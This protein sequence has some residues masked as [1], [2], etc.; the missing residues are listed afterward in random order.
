VGTVAFA[1]ICNTL[2]YI[3]YLVFTFWAKKAVRLSKH[4]EVF[5]AI[6]CCSECG[7]KCV[8]T[9]SDYLNTNALA[10]ISITG[11][12]YCEGAWK[13]LMCVVKHS[14]EFQSSMTVASV[15]MFGIKIFVTVLNLLTGMFVMY[16]IT[17]SGYQ[18]SEFYF[19][20]FMISLFSY[21]ISSLFLNI[22][23][24][25]CQALIM[26]LAVD[27]DINDGK[28]EYGPVSFHEAIHNVK[29]HNKK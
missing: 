21:A 6:I 18:V 26:C 13:G 17:G 3:V 20:M 27:M 22:F 19:P 10:Y 28:P 25:V 23:M 8:E 16:D 4:N 1:S 11:D 15:F 12:G 2:V 14:L 24:T 9:I 29:S 7:L 5:K